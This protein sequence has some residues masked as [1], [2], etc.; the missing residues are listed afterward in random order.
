MQPASEDIIEQLNQLTSI[1]SGEIPAY[2]NPTIVEERFDCELIDGTLVEMPSYH[3]FY[4]FTKEDFIDK[5]STLSLTHTITNISYD[6]TFGTT[7]MVD[8]KV[9]VA[10]IT[11]FN[12]NITPEVME[13]FYKLPIN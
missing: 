2:V 1:V 11:D 3:N 8:M 9:Y 5:L 7:V 4:F 6:S 12:T 13:L 10:E